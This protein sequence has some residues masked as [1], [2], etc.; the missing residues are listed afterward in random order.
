MSRSL[1]GG[2]EH[3]ITHANELNGVLINT[4]ENKA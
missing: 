2:R 1:V 4:R 3:Q